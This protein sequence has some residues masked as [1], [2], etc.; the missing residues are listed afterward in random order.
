MIIIN[1]RKILILALLSTF[2]SKAAPHGPIFG[3]GPD[4][5]RKGGYAIEAEIEHEIV[6]KERESVLNAEIIYG[7]TEYLSIS[8]VMPFFLNVEHQENGTS[9]S[10]KS[11]GLDKIE[12]QA[13]L[14]IYHD[15]QYGH[16]DQAVIIGGIRLPTI[17]QAQDRDTRL[18]VHAK[19]PSLGNQS[20][21]FFIALA[22]GREMLQ[23]NYFCSLQYVVNTRANHIKEGNELTLTLSTGFRP[24]LIS[25]RDLDWF[26]SMEFNFINTEKSLKYGIPEINSGGYTGYIGPTVIVSKNNIA[27]KAGIQAPMFEQVNGE[28]DKHD[29]RFAAGLD[30]HF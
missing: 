7:A 11:A 3:L 20:L 16:R 5:I 1:P 12:T 17:S 2:F 13:K 8:A 28:Q 4:L 15:Y 30:L 25:Y 22:A 29:L 9:Q 10:F 19:N 14:R 6:G 26:F 27:F 24:S 21:D 18:P 23:K